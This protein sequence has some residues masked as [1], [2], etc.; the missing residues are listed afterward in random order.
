M[1]MPGQTA[2]EAGATTSGFNRPS[3]VGPCE[4]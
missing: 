2:V 4:E 3:S 1:A